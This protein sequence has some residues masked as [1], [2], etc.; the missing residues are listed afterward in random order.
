MYKEKISKIK[1][2]KVKNFQPPVTGE[3][4]IDI[5]AIKPSKVI[6]EIK[7]E[8]KNQILDGKIKNTKKDA[9]TL[10]FKIAKKHGLNPKK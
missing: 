9:K 2:D 6:G 10:L 3:E 7:N 5:F 1:N 8:I 4:I